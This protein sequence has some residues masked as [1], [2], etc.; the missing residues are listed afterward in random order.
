MIN[1][2][3]VISDMLKQNTGRSFLDS[4][5][6]Y[7]RHY[8]KSQKV[9]NF[10]N[11]P[12]IEVEIFENDEELRDVLVTVNV[13]HFLKNHLEYAPKKDKEFQEYMNNSD[14]K[15]LQDMQ[16]FGKINGYDISTI[17]TYNQ[18]SVL[19]QILQFSLYMQDDIYNTEYIALQI[20][21][22]CDTRGGYTRPKIFK[23]YDID[24]FMMGIRQ[25][26]VYDTEGQV[27]GYSD[28]GGYNWYDIDEEEVIFDSDNN[29][30]YYKFRGNE[31]NF[32]GLLEF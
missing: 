25:L 16:D 32:D 14:K 15:Y 26:S 29:K 2:K 4:G 7:G 9:E 10:D 17:N 18:E 8:E 6:A 22:G 13:Y 11:T 31:L 20:H 28:D 23:V 3:E 27:Y 21:N 30:A 1:T 19:S 24:Y 12:R 5:G